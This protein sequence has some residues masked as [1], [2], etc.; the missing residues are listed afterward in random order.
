MN[1][2][3]SPPSPSALAPARPAARRGWGWLLALLLLVLLAGGLGGAWWWRG[4]MA[5]P[6]P[7]QGGNGTQVPADDSQS[8][9]PLCSDEDDPKYLEHLEFGPPIEVRLDRRFLDAL[10]GR[11][12]PAGEVYPWQPKE[13]VAILGEHRMRGNLMAASPD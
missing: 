11:P 7:G 2:K 10:P 12:L 4:R 5:A 13:L 6:G 3:T 1:G 8:K 9:L